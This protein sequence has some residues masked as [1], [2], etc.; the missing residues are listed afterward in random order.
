VGFFH[1]QSGGAMRDE[2]ADFLECARVEQLVKTFTRRLLVLGVL[3]LD[4]SL[5]T[6]QN[7]FGTDLL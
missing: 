1:A 3:R 7:G 6:P 5:S 4:A 2:S